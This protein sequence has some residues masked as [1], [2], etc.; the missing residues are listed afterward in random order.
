MR[1]FNALW[2]ALREEDC[3]ERKKE[4]DNCQRIENMLKRRGRGRKKEE[5]G[6]AER[7]R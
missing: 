6:E 1:A 7:S 3:S 2:K 4:N 5:A